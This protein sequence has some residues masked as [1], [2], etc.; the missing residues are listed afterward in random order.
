MLGS[1]EIELNWK[2][3]DVTTADKNKVLGFGKHVKE[4]M[5]NFIKH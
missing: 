4:V 1:V 2:G 3:T 5:L